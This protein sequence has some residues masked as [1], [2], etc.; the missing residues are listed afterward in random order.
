MQRSRESLEDQLRRLA[1]R[2][3]P[4]DSRPG[5]DREEGRSAAR[6]P[7]AIVHVRGPCAELTSG[8]LLVAYPTKMEAEHARDE[9]WA[10]AS[11]TTT[12]VKCDECPCFHLVD[13]QGLPLA[14]RT[15]HISDVGL[16]EPQSAGKQRPKCPLCRSTAGVAKTAFGSVADAQSALDSLKVDVP[17]RLGAY[18]CPHGYGVHL[19]KKP[20]FRAGQQIASLLQRRFERRGAASQSRTSMNIGSVAVEGSIQTGEIGVVTSEVDEGMPFEC[21]S[22]KYKLNKRRDLKCAWCGKYGPYRTL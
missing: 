2:A 10:T 13:L 15:R 6:R 5:R 20:P 7:A 18:R 19:T 4:Q 12:V 14:D 16:P 3:A 9:L 1:P 17:Y 8:L 21:L 11:M 22:C